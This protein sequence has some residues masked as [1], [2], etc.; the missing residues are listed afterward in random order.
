MSDYDQSY[1]AFVSV[2][3][4]FSVA[5]GVVVSLEL[6]FRLTGLAGFE[7]STYRLGGGRSILL[8]YSPRDRVII[9][10]LDRVQQIL[11]W[12]GRREWA[13]AETSRYKGFSCVTL[14]LKLPPA[15]SP[16]AR[17]RIK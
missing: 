4:A 16:K 2:V 15:N 5:Q 14:S 1:Q 6:K 11:L 17:T 7:P 3:S 12:M 9:A 13:M 8:S 10:S